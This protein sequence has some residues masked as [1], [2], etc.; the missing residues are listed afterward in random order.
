MQ[1]READHRVERP[2]LERERR[3]VTMPHVHP[4]CLPA[5]AEASASSY[6]THVNEPTRD[7]S[8][9]VVSPGPGPSSRTADRSREMPS[10]A[11][12]SSALTW[13]RQSG[14]RQ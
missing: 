9:S 6:S 1:H 10:N 2:G 12:G 5:S 11:H 8:Q 14:D 3:R 13:A 7:T 4:G